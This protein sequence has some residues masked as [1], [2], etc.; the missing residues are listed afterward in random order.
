APLSVDFNGRESYDPDGII[1]SYFWDWGGSTSNNAETTVLFDQGTYNVTLTVIDDDGDSDFS[2]VNVS[3][4][5]DEGDFD[6]DGVMNSE[7]NCPLIPN[8]GQEFFLFYEDADGDGLGDPNN[9]VEGC[10]PPF[11]YVTNDN[12]NCPAVNALD[13]TD[14]DNDGLGD[15][16]DPDADDD[17]YLN[18]DDCQPL[19]AAVALPSLFYADADGDGFGDPNNSL[20][21][22]DQPAGYVANNLDNCPDTF[23]PGQTDT[24]NDGVGNTCDNSVLGLNEFW[25]EAECALVGSNW[26]TLSA[27]DASNGEYVNFPSGN[28]YNSPPSNIAENRIRFVIDRAQPGT[29]HLF[30]RIKTPSPAG[31]NNSFWVRVNDGA[32]QRWYEGINLSG[33][34]QWNESLGSP[35]NLVDGTNIVDFLY[36]EDGTQLDKIVLTLSDD[37]PSGEG[38]QASNC[39]TIPNDPPV[40]VATATPTTGT[41]PLPVQLD[42][43]GSFD[44]DGGIFEYAWT[45]ENGGQAEGVD[46]AVVFDEGDYNVT[47][48]VTDDDGASDSDMLLVSVSSNVTDSDGD[49]V[50]D[51]VDNCPNVPNPNQE[52]NTY[53][54]DADGDGF[55]DP[56]DTI[57]DC[58]LPPGYVENADDNCP[59]FG[60]FNLTDTDEDGIGNVCDD[61][62]DADGVLDE[63]D[64]DPLDP[65]VGSGPVFYADFDGDGFGDPDS[66]INACS[67]PANYVSNNTDNCPAIYNPD[68][69]DTDGDGIGDVCD[70]TVPGENEFWLEAECAQVG[71]NWTEITATSASNDAYLSY[72][73][74]RSVSSPPADLPENYVRFSVD[75]VAEGEYYLYARARAQTSKNDSYWGRINGGAWELWGNNF[76]AGSDFVWF[77]VS[78]DPYDLNEGMNTIDFAYRE[79]DSQLDKIYFGLV[80]Q[81]PVGVGGA[82]QNCGNAAPVAVA[83]ATPSTGVAPL[84]VQLDGSASSDADNAIVGY[85]WNWGEGVVTGMDPAVTFVN[86]GVY[87]VTLTVTDELGA[88]GTDVVVVTADAPPNQ[89]PTAVAQ[90]TPL[91]GNEPLT[92]D[93]DGSGSSDVDGFLVN[94]SWDWGTGVGSGSTLTEVFDGGTYDITLTVTDNEGATDTDVIQVVVFD[95]STD[96]DS[97]GIVDSQDNCPTVP[98]PNQELFVF[99]ADADADGFGDPNDSIME[100]A[101]PMGYVTNSSD[102]CPHTYNP[103]QVD[104]DQDGIGDACDTDAPGRTYFWL[105][106]ECAEVG[107]SWV[108]NPDTEASRGA[109]VGYYGPRAIS[110]PPADIEDNYVRFDIDGVAAGNY[111]L[112]ARV[113]AASQSNDSYWGRVNGGEW[114]LW[115]NNFSTGVGFLWTEVNNSPFALR[116]RR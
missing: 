55:G 69:T 97:D 5:D 100:C 43:S 60:S 63:A 2:V 45:W 10:D 51:E 101:A 102:N 70:P 35:F 21:D 14:T 3:V 107:A 26:Q 11:G 23:N 99:Y 28:S 56:T 87:Y 90:A 17:G 8:P 83:S 113:R 62:D 6:G 13:F 46:P 20:S 4:V 59:N 52:I 98:N 108:E 41:A 88:V 32:W 94:F 91:S 73:G 44:N 110:G 103:D 112:L 72:L 109:Y 116:G 75:G 12:D 92:V 53:Y 86:S 105:E 48:T 66:P 96:T 76:P 85:Q 80:D 18:E 36:R 22:C 115:G 111:H 61:D 40:A 15:V 82:S 114:T 64:C 39:T 68:Q 71:S 65:N 58:E 27:G 50:L 31:A 54:R 47:L 84:A 81:L 7:D 16:C 30:A 57:Q 93:L 95:S 77:Q 24:D 34:F 33:T 25:L 74:T 29:Y 49:G 19:N 106:A 89:A 104:L 79:S 38:S 78:I 1:T 9:F 42:G 37:L 67:T